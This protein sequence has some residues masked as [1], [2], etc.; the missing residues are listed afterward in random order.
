M[1]LGAETNQVPAG[2]TVPVYTDSERDL[3]TDLSPIPRKH[4]PGPDV[5]GA[6]TLVGEEVCDPDMKSLGK[7]EEIMLDV[8]SGRIAYAVLSFG[9]FLGMG[10][11]LFAIPWSS[12]ELDIA[13]KCFILGIDAERLKTAPGFDKDNWPTMADTAWADTIHDF[14]QRP[15]YW[16]ENSII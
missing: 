10:E 7:I 1:K 13:N 12:L 4:G 16:K 3:D 6:K 14:Y 8:G 15:P 2:R 9:G 5:M 11:K